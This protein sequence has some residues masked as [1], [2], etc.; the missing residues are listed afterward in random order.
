MALGLTPALRSTSRMGAWP[1]WQEPCILT[2][3]ASHPGPREDLGHAPCMG[4]SSGK[5]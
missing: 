2:A 1:S 5:G 3:M 4:R